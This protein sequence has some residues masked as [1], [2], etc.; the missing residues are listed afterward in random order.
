MISSPTENHVVQICT[1]S[2]SLIGSSTIAIMIFTSPTGLST[3]Y[4]RIIFG[5]SIADIMQSLALVTGPFS[6]PRETPQSPWSIG[7][8]STCETNGFLMTAGS[9]AVTMYTCSLCIF[10]LSKLVYRMSNHNFTRRV[11][12]YLHVFIVLF[13]VCV[14]IW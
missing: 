1:S 12:I 14:R 8:T 10:Y 11:E 2:I 6:P 5:L 9:S 4:K 13:N 3:P 7:N